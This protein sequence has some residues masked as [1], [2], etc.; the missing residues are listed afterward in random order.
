MFRT[1]DDVGFPWLEAGS[2]PTLLML[3]GWSQSASMFRE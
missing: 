3:P 1:S 2:G